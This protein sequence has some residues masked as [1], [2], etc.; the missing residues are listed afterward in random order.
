M[1]TE[2]PKER[3]QRWRREFSGF[4]RDRHFDLLEWA[5]WFQNADRSVSWTELS[6]NASVSTVFLGLNHNYSGGPPLLFET[7]IIRAGEFD[8]H[9][10]YGTWDEAERG[11][12]EIVAAVCLEENRTIIE[13]NI[14]EAEYLFH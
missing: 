9:S 4:M 6:G 8:I 5:E 3:W 1:G 2:T 14:L 13:G 11:H 10:R 7:A 12:A